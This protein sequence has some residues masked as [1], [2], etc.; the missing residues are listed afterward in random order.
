MAPDRV[1]AGR[2]RPAHVVVQVVAD[3]EALV[4]RHG[5][6]PVAAGTTRAATAAAEPPEDPPG[7]NEAFQGFVTGPK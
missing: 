4:R 5:A 7:D 3:G 2:Q 1:V 6:V